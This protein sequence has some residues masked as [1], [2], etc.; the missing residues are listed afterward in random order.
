MVLTTRARVFVVVIRV[1][2]ALSDAGLGGG[3]GGADDDGAAVSAGAPT[4]GFL[5]GLEMGLSMGPVRR[6]PPQGGSGVVAAAAAAAAK[7]AAKAA[8]E[9]VVSLLGQAGGGGTRKAVVLSDAVEALVSSFGLKSAAVSAFLFLLRFFVWRRRETHTHTEIGR[10]CP[11]KF[12][13][14][15]VRFYCHIAWSGVC[16]CVWPQ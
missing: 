13:R 2:A 8:S 16:V 11:C 3:G 15:G 12:W 4:G 6:P 9:A 5:R 14:R 10:D 7:S 1:F